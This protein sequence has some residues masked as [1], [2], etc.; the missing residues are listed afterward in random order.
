M[1]RQTLPGHELSIEQGTPDVP[2]DSNYYVRHKGKTVGRFRALAQAQ[3]CYQKIKQSLRIE[4]PPPAGTLSV[5]DV[6]R[7]ELDSQSNKSLL[8]SDDD[9][10]RVDRKTRGRPKH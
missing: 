7:R 3:K 4:P 10:A 5:A 9:F 6:M 8:W 2:N 1:Y